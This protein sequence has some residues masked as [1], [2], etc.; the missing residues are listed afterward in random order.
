MDGFSAEE[1]FTKENGFA[2]NDFI[3][4]PGYIDF[5]PD[6]VVLESNLTRNIRIKNPLVSSPMDTVTDSRMAIGLALLGGIGIIHYNNT[7]EEQAN[8]VRK[9]KRFENGFI[10]DP[11]VLSPGNTIAD[12]DAIKAKYG[13]SGIPI[14]ENGKLNSLLLGIVSNRDIDFE[15]DRSKKLLDVMTTDLVTAKKGISLNEANQILK[16]SKKGKLPIVDD[17]GR[18]IALMSRKDLVKNREYPLASKDPRKQL[19]VGAAI[20]TREES[21]ERLAALVEAGV[22]VVVVDA[23]QGN[24]I[25]QIEMIK[26]I[27]KKYPDIEVIGGNVVTMEQSETIIKAGADAL[28]IGMGPGSICTTQTTM[29]VGRAQATAVY[30]T[31]KMAREYNVPVIADGGIS[32]I[33]HIA[34]ALALGAS[35]VM[36]GSMFAG[37]NE[38]P[39]EYFY[40]NGV[41][42]KKY[43]GMASQ[44]ALEAGGAK[45]YFAEDTKIKVVQGVSGTVLDKGSIFEYVPYLIQGL[46]HSFQDMGTR[47]IAVLHERLRKG[48][49][50]FELRSPSAQ[51]EG[52]VHDMYSYKEPK[53]M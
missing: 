51:L 24:S 22:N 15:T 31:A 20:S 18:L 36:M 35:S 39:G 4:L 46:K 10:N 43:R 9:V 47:D 49:L 2:Y 52:G 6:E 44:E 29:A 12:I 42:L 3:I 19:M 16:N 11:I 38:A 26:Y 17:K 23:A 25:Y 37:T 8:E 27:K 53:Y 30:R 33:G 45:R 50:R 14:T 32:T 21:R 13:F 34:K 1:I 7:I 40:E 5:A 28:R 41:R 48:T